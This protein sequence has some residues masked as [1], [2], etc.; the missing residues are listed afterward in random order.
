MG[1]ILI[2][3]D[4]LINYLLCLSKAQYQLDGDTSEILSK[5]QNNFRICFNPNKDQHESTAFG[6]SSSMHLH[7]S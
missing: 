4:L 2:N 1:H 3:V 6:Y 5:L 7:D